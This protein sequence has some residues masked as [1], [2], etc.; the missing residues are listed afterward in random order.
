MTYKSTYR[1]ALALV[2]GLV[3]SGVASAFVHISSV[4][5]HLPVSPEHPRITFQWNGD[6]PKLS[7][8]EKVFDGLYAESSD[9]ELMLAL[10]NAAVG[11]WNDVESAY[12]FFDVVV[13]AGVVK[14]DEDEI[15]AIVVE[16]QDSQTVAAASLPMFVSAHPGDSL[17]KKSGKIIF[18]CDISVSSHKVPAKELL[19]TLV[20]ELGHCVGLGH[21]HSSYHSIMSYANVSSSAELGL[22]DKAGISY[23]YPQAGVSQDVQYMTTC[24][25]LGSE[26]Q[27]SGAGNLVLLGS[28]L[29]LLLVALRRKKG[30]QASG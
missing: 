20:H 8:K 12:L 26:G 28:P 11:K 24:S 7:E 18:D 16:G 17:N 23:L 6:A 22:D 19:R 25:S 15:Y 27:G 2:C 13:N 9:A 4:K 14:D 30:F 3:W 1:I 10:L 5:P 21:P 29:L